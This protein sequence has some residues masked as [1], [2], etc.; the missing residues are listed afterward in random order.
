MKKT[1]IFM[2]IIS[3]VFLFFVNEHYRYDGYKLTYLGYDYLALRA[4]MKRGNI[5]SV[6]RRIGVGKE[7][8]IYLVQNEEGETLALKLQRLGRV[9]FRAIKQVIFQIIKI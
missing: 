3:I 1:G 7:S 4:M 6:G 8:D 2:I 5:V 9:S